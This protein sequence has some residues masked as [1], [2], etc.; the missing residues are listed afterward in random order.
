MS[1]LPTKRKSQWEEF[2]TAVKSFASGGGAGA[3][4]KTVV[5]PAERLKVLMQVEFMKTGLIL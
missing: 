2:V 3:I 5:A 1:Q 4:S